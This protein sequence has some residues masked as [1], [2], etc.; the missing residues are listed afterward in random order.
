MYNESWGEA[1]TTK[2]TKLTPLSYERM[3]KPQRKGKFKPTKSEDRESQGTE[4]DLLCWI[5]FSVVFFSSFNKQNNEHKNLI[6]SFIFIPCRKKEIY[7]SSAIFLHLFWQV[8]RDGGLWTWKIRRFCVAHRNRVELM[9][10]WFCFREVFFCHESAFERRVELNLHFFSR[11]RK[12]V[13]KPA[14]ANLTSNRKVRSR[15]SDLLNIQNILRICWTNIC[16]I[17]PP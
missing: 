4:K 7:S 16:N 14:A 1:A 9:S 2:T 3:K 8:E 12:S 17:S 10:F 11:R 15:E 6:S 13:E 5:W